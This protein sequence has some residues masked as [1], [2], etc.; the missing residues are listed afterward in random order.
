MTYS[1]LVGNPDPDTVI[2][3]IAAGYGADVTC[4]PA[5]A[6]DYVDPVF[7]GRRQAFVDCGGPGGDMFIQ[8]ALTSTDGHSVEFGI[9]LTTADDPSII[10]LIESTITLGPG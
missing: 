7:S 1:L 2:S 4:T 5:P 10:E 6:T 8:Y 9:Q 3:Q